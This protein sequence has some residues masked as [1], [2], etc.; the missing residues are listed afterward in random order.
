M[1]AMASSGSRTS[2]ARCDPSR[3]ADA[4]LVDGEPV[5]FVAPKRAP[6]RRR[7]ASGSFA[8]PQERARVAMPSRIFVEGRHDAELVEQVWGD[9]LRVEGIVVE[10][11]DGADHL[12][13]VLAEFQPGPARRAGVLLDHLVA[14]SKETRIAEAIARGTHGAHVRI[15]G[16]PYIDIW[17]AVK[18]ERL[19]LTQWPRIPRGTDWK[20]GICLSLG[21]PAEDLADIADAW[22]RIRGR[23]RNFR[24]LEPQ[25]VGRVEELIDFVSVGQAVGHSSACPAYSEW[26]TTQRWVQ[27]LSRANRFFCS[28]P[29]GRDPLRRAQCS[30]PMVLRYCV[31]IFPQARA[32][33]F[34][35]PRTPATRSARQSRVSARSLLP[36]T[37]HARSFAGR[38]DLAI[39]LGGDCAS[40]L[41]GIERAVARD[42]GVAVLWI[43]AQPRPPASGNVTLWRSIG[44]DTQAR[45]RCSVRDDLNAATPVDPA[46]VLLVGA[47]E[48]DQEEA[49]AITAARRPLGASACRRWQRPQPLQRGS[50]RSQATSLYIHID[51]DVLDPADFSSV[52]TAV[53]FGFTPLRSLPR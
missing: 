45:T 32:L 4:F 29:S 20:T 16:H 40:T 37:P 17:E 35:C 8:A 10:L 34:R 44:D 26:I 51:L 41:A 31:R 47:R 43:D 49:E 3:A 19:G 12:E 1:H 7:T 52:H 15:V 13:R 5:T 30:S 18:P 50:L 11:L 42:P 48:V 14:G 27:C 23:V 24:D 22:K 25:L 28:C 9:D 33:T 6:V 39:T 21:W 53:P 38:D 46:R 36:A 2:T